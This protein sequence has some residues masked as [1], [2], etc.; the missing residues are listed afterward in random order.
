MECLHGRDV[1]DLG[2]TTTWFGGAKAGTAIAAVELGTRLPSAMQ[3]PIFTKV[4]GPLLE[5]RYLELLSRVSQ[6]AGSVR[7]HQVQTD[8]GAL[9]LAWSAYGGGGVRRNSGTVLVRASSA[10]LPD[11]LNHRATDR[12][13]ITL[14]DE[15]GTHPE[16][17]RWSAA[18][19]NDGLR[20]FGWDW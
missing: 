17:R 10:A 6:P 5:R 20:R 4:A 16:S 7:L 19:L 2:W 9:P 12:L 13:L 14:A 3:G 18:G 8:A 15:A 11:R 1:R